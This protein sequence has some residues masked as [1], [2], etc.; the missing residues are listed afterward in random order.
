MSRYFAQ[1]LLLLVPTLIGVTIIVF[2]LLRLVPG[3]AVGALLGDNAT[4]EQAAILKHALGFDLPIWLQYLKW[5][6]GV[7]HG[8]L[9][10]SLLNQT[11]ISRDIASRI[12]WTFELGAFALGFSMLVALPVGILSAIRQDKPVDYLARSSAIAFLAIPSF[13]LATLLIVYGAIGLQIGDLSLHFTPP[14]GREI[15]ADLGSNLRLVLPPALILGIGLSGSVMR[16]TR[17]QMLEVMRQDYIRTAQAKGLK[18]WVV[19]ARHALRN[20][21]I[22]VITIIGLQVPVL[23]GGSVILEQI[24]SLPGMGYYLVSAV[25]QRD[26]TAIQGVVLVSATIVIVS[27]L[28]V[29]LTYSLLDPRIRYA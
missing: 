7:L 18:L 5:V 11:P 3:G 16:L 28:L 26:I 27:N 8:D 6:G 22:P 2:A 10:K 21:L 13:W 14:L 9:G 1:R 17:T 25:S 4:P 23:V 19:I 15:D 24:F 12:G 29:D 20:A